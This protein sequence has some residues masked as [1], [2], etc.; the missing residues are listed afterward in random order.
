[1][2]PSSTPSTLRLAHNECDLLE[3]KQCDSQATQ[4]WNTND[5]VEGRGVGLAWGEEGGRPA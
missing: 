1:V 4:V 5:G 3:M 2:A